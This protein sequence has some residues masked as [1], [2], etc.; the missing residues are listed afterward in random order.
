[1]LPT[2]LA[3]F[4]END[5]EFG[6]KMISLVEDPAIG[7]VA[8]KMSAETELKLSIQNEEEQ[9]I[10]TPV[11]IPMQK[12]M[13][14]FENEEFN[15]VFDRPTIKKVAIKWSKDGLTNAS[16]INHSGSLI[17]GVTFFESFIKGERV[18]S[19]IGFDE[20]PDGTW[21]VAGKVTD[22]K[23]WQLIKEDKIKGVSID[24]VFK[25]IA[26]QQEP[27]TD[28]QLATILAMLR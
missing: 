10:F 19:V 6:L 24:G 3:V 14:R 23:V 26:V 12:I 8:I 2:K 21:F 9:I 18:K 20:V 25:A 1:M 17:P 28:Q 15:L 11:L 13:R 27:T 16:D 4:D 22:S 5:P 7:F